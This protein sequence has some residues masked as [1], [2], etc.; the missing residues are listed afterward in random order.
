M[1]RRLALLDSLVALKGAH[2]QAT[3]MLSDIMIDAVRAS[4]GAGAV[5]EVN[6][7]R[8]Y[9]KAVKSLKIQ[10]LQ[11]ELVLAELDNPGRPE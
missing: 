10:C 4:K 8:A 6:S 2:D 9:R 1:E 7:M 11:V 5:P 3:S